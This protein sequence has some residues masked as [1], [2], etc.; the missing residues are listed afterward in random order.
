[1]KLLPIV[2][3]VFPLAFAVQVSIAL[4]TRG[5]AEGGCRSMGT[6][7]ATIILSAC[8]CG[9][10]SAV[11]RT[12]PRDPRI[13]HGPVMIFVTGRTA[14]RAFVCRHRRGRISIAY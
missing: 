7:V 14:V 9:S 12:T 11:T 5:R 8:C 13:V 2:T 10:A 1:V 6:I 3:F 4:S